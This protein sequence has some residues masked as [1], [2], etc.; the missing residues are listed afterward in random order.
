VIDFVMRAEGVSFR[1]A[2]ELLASRRRAGASGRRAAVVKRTTLCKLEPLASETAEDAE[3]M[4]RVV[5]HYQ[6]SAAR[7]RRGAG[8][9]SRART[10]GEE[11]RHISAGAREPHAGLPA[12][13]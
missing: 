9:T 7:E 5:D 10:L 13:A 2:V 8:S 12:A 4:S 11:V 3:L 6:A 1:H